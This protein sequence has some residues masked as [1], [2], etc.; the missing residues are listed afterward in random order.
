MSDWI[1][2]TAD[3][4]NAAG[5]ASASA[6]G[7]KRAPEPGRVGRRAVRRRRICTQVKFKPD[8]GR[9]RPKRRNAGLFGARGGGRDPLE[10]KRA[11]PPRHVK[12]LRLLFYSMRA[13]RLDAGV[14]WSD[15]NSK[16][17]LC[18]ITK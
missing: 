15:I 18:E 2:R 14:P 8:A 10:L 11:W 9:G 5:A 6:G 1:P 12:K 13:H 16:I 4:A 3:A 7:T 17:F